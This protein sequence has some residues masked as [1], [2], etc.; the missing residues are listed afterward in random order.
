MTASTPT[1]P[2]TSAATITAASPCGVALSLSGEFE[3]GFEGDNL[4]L[5]LSLFALLFVVSAEHHR[6][7]LLFGFVGL[8]LLFVGVLPLH[9]VFG[10]RRRFGLGL[11]RLILLLKLVPTHLRRSR[12]LL[13]IQITETVGLTP[14]LLRRL[15]VGARIRRVRHAV[16]DLIR[17]G[18][19][20]SGT[21]AASDVL[22]I[23]R[24]ARAGLAVILALIAA[25][26][27]SGLVWVWC[28]VV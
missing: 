23:D 21:S 12:I 16:L 15:I 6:V 18:T 27:D 7:R 24:L 8:K 10:V 20:I 14:F 3:L 13:P 2:A 28:S 25:H 22:A 9:G 4:F 26:A 5:L 11:L 19:P 17:G 1:T